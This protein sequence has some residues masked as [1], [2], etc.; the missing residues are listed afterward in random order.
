MDLQ[1]IIKAEMN[2]D[3]PIE[4]LQKL[5]EQIFDKS[6]V[7]LILTDHDLNIWRINSLASEITGWV[8]DHKETNLLNLIKIQDV[9]DINSYIK[10]SRKSALITDNLDDIHGSVEL[11]TTE[12]EDGFLLIQLNKLNSKE[13]NLTAFIELA[14]KKENQLIKAIIDTSLYPFCIVDLSNNC[15]LIRN[16][17]HI[18]LENNLIN[19]KNL[20]NIPYLID[21]TFAFGLFQESINKFHNPFI[22]EHEYID[23]QGQKVYYEIYAY[24]VISNK[25]NNRYVILHYRD[26]TQ[27]INERIEIEQYRKTLQDLFVN[28][29]GMVFRCLNETNWTIEFASSGCKCL[30]GYSV[31]ELVNNSKIHY[32]DLIHPEDRQMVWDLIQEAVKRKRQYEIKYRIVTK[33]GK[34]KWV[35]ERGKANYDQNDQVVSIN[36]FITDISEGIIAEINLKKELQISEAIAQISLKLLED[37]VTPIEVSRLVQDYMIEFSGSSF[38]V[39]YSPEENGLGV[40]LYNHSDPEEII[41]INSEKYSEPQMIFLQKLLECESPLIVNESV[42]IIL[43]G[44]FDE[45][46]AI[47][48]YV[49][50]PAFINKKLTGLLIIGN[51]IKDY[52]NEIV[53]TGQRF[54]N[55]FAL[56]LYRLKAEETLQ[57][58]KSKAEESDRLKSLF[59]SNMSHEIRTPM[60]A[61]V[62]FA[63]M[64][65]DSDLD[66]EQKNRF[67]DVIIKSGDNL[68]RL[69]NDIIDISKIE[70]GQLKLDYSDC[71]VNEMISDL[72][73]YFKQELIRLKKPHINLYIQLGH[74]ESDFA[75][76]TDCVRLKQIL[77][78]LIGNAIK[79]TD[80]GFIEFGYKLKAGT[81]EFF[82][83]DSGIGIATDKQTLIFERFGQV[84]EAISRNLA[85]TGLGLT[86]SKNLVEMLGGEI[87]VDSIPGEGST[88]FFTL[89]MRLG[90]NQ[91]KK[92]NIENPVE[93]R[94]S[95]DLQGKTILIV[96][97]VDTNYFYLSS[98]LQK[99]NCKII[100]ANNGKKAIEMCQDDE[101]IDLVLMDI[102]LPILNGYQATSEIKKLRPTL[103]VIAQTAFAMMGERERSR[104]AGCDD[105]IAKPIR[106]E[107][108]LSILRKFIKV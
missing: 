43:P 98:L 46:T 66:R 57:D 91:T 60:N 88:F 107:E 36:G 44:L 106:K 26:I 92:A 100:R 3:T 74:P 73:T 37:N 15:Y 7:P 94:N 84:Q 17:A 103:P 71:L 108:L 48:R 30:T 8:L 75:L 31:E 87:R 77:N 52:E 76:K 58:A 1:G 24:P 55:M 93:N 23:L 67:L 72:E 90:T 101:S 41:T 22:E 83:R 59:L 38:S 65:Q 29:P 45:T 50:I 99:H 25:N 11:Y 27:E 33:K 61:I 105:Y 5:Y 54:I 80:D 104:E 4:S 39:I 16:K 102:E 56:G 6:S 19:R 51:S 12:L 79:F 13:D 69:I 47:E 63:E 18:D 40:T 82:V 2:R 9:V 78:N 35:A 34:I 85:G 64:L 42:N 70:A 28:L 53:A 14:Q 95:L 21:S 81:I 49:S 32:A 68:L 62:G 10:L 96:E 20:D 89:P 86:I 97:D